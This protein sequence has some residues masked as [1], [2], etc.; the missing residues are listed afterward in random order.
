MLNS[1]MSRKCWTN[2]IHRAFPLSVFMPIREER[3]K[4]GDA[5]SRNAVDREVCKARLFTLA[6][7]KEAI[8][9][10][11]GG[12][13]ETAR[14]GRVVASDNRRTERLFSAYGLPLLTA[15][16]LVRRVLHRRRHR[17]SRT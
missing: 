9:G 8:R 15:Q 13:Q 17:P 2:F 7:E 1:S 16:L 11:G 5:S 10:G 14:N 6:I 4:N 12:W 3:L